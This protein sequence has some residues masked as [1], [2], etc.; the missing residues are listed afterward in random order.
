MECAECREWLSARMDGEDGE[1]EAAAGDAHV[2]GCASCR[3]FLLSAE[4]LARA[5]RWRPAEAVPDLSGAILSAASA[6]SPPLHRDLARVALAVVAAAEL[7]LAVPALVLGNDAGATVHLSRHLG[8]FDVAIAV[9][10]LVA[11]WQPDRAR[12][13]LPVAGVLGLAMAAA[14]GVDLVDGAA[15]V[16]PEAHVV[17]EAAGFVLLW[18]VADAPTPWRGSGRVPA[19]SRPHSPAPLA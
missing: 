14:A 7:L 6:P 5:V 1:A 8:A 11:A 18:R 3:A 17:L 4:R 2:A 12:G 10:L 13:L 19:R 9:G 15:A 16:T